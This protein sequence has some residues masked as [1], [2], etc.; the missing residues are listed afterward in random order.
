LTWGA[1][2]AAAVVAVGTATHVLTS[3]GVGVAPTFQAPA[4]V[5]DVTAAAAMVANTLLTGDD[6]AKGIQDT[7]VSV[8]ATDHMYAIETLGFNSAHAIGNS[9]SAFTVTLSNGQHQT[10]TMTADAA[11][12]IV[13]TGNIGDGKWTVTIS[14]DGT[15]GFSITSATV[16]GGTVTSPGGSNL[17]LTAAASSVDT[18]EIIKEG[19]IYYVRVSELD[20]Q[21]WA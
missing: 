1:T 5:G 12:T 21:T 10:L 14:Q 11:M 8:D 19:S 6:G 9:S 7:G 15:G 13:D 20:Y 4:T 2:T 18:I 16:S 17:A 3:N